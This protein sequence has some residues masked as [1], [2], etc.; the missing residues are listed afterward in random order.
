M[1]E[2][3]FPPVLACDCCGREAQMD[4]SPFSPWWRLKEGW[5]YVPWEMRRI[6]GADDRATTAL[7]VCTACVKALKSA[8][9]DRQ[10]PKEA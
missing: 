5:E 10:A 4:H 1:A 2:A 8:W 7:K 6:L 3:K 9:A